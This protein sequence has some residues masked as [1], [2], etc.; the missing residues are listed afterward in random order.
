MA[1]GLSQV[2]ADNVKASMLQLV[3]LTCTDMVLRRQSSIIMGETSLLNYSCFFNI[4]RAA[5]RV[6]PGDPLTNCQPLTCSAK[7]NR[8]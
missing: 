6:R 7:L 1:R 5:G 8:A 2:Q 4:N 3:T